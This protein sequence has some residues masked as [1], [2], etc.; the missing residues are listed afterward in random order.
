MRASD[1]LVKQKKSSQ[2][3]YA[4]HQLPVRTIME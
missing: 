2:C 4:G 1:K 3:L